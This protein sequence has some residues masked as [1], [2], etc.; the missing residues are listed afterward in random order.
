MRLNPQTIRLAILLAMVVFAV[1]CG[2]WKWELP[3]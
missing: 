3:H 1:F 2:G